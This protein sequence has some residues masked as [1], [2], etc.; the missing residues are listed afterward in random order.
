M[1]VRH[2]QIATISQRMFYSESADVADDD[3]PVSFYPRKRTRVLVRLDQHLQHLHSGRIMNYS[4]KLQPADVDLEHLQSSAG[5]QGLKR[6]PVKPYGALGHQGSSPHA[7]ARILTSKFRTLTLES[8][9]SR[10]KSFLSPIVRL[11]NRMKTNKMAA[12]RELLSA[13][14]DIGPD[15]IVGALAKQKIKITT[16]VASNYKSVIKSGA[17]R[18]KKK[19]RRAAAK[20]SP[21]ATV[22]TATPVSNSTSKTGLDPDV[23]SLLKAGQTLGWKK[24]RAITELMLDK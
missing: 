16:G 3:V 21:M 12:V 20:S 23:I 22:P 9:R 18:G 24:V 10:D 2:L 14:P 6:A 5:G 4:I 1:I 13:N 17:K 8:G 11:E 19:G 7:G 15:E